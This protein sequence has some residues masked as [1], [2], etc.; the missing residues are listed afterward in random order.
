MHLLG[1]AEGV[2]VALAGGR[3]AVVEA[4]VLLHALPPVLHLVGI[5]HLVLACFDLLWGSA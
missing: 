3:D 1:G 2:D 4:V 5:A